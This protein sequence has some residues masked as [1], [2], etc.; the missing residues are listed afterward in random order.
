MPYL[1]SSRH[2]LPLSPSPYDDDVRSSP[3]SVH[4]PPPLSPSL[5]LS[6][7]SSSSSSSRGP[8][9]PSLPFQT[10]DDDP[11]A[12]LSSPFFSTPEPKTKGVTV[13]KTRSARSSTPS[14]GLQGLPERPSVAAGVGFFGR[15][16]GEG[17]RGFE[18]LV[19]KLGR[20]RKESP[21]SQ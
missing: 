5:S 16:L 15:A 3:S 8:A 2:F 13:V 12:F 6:S 10:T 20:E 14:G 4:H 7:A 19:R 9:S 11:L 21:T 17:E 18:Y 1:T